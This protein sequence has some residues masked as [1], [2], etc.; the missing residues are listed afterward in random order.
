MELDISNTLKINAD[1]IVTGRTCVIGQSGSG[2]SYTVAVICEELAKNN[3]GFCIIDTEGEYFSLKE[4]Y[5]ILWIGSDPNADI[6]IAAVNMA[7]LARKI[8][9]NG[10]PA[11][12][13]VSEVDDPKVVVGEF[14]K[15][16]YKIETK[17]RQP[18]LLIIEEIDKFAPQR[19]ETLPEVEEVSRRGRKRGLG[20]MIAT[21]RPALVNKNVLSQCGNQIIGKLTIRNDLDSVKV[22]FPDKEK[23]ESLPTLKQGQFY[24]MGDIGSGQLIQVRKRLTTH[25]AVTPAIVQ[26]KAIKIEDIKAIEEEIESP[27]KESAIEEEEVEDVKKEIIPVKLEKGDAFQQIKSKAKGFI[28]FGGETHLSGFHLALRPIYLCK[29]KYLKKGLIGSNYLDMI[30]YFD[31]I[32][33]D[34]VSISNGYKIKYKTSELIGLNQADLCILKT[35]LKSSGLTTSELAYKC[36]CSE[37]S[38]RESIKNLTKKHMITYK[39]AG[40]NVLHMPFTKKQIPDINQLSEKESVAE[41]VKIS[42]RLEKEEVDLKGLREIVRGINEESDIVEHKTV[43]YPFYVA[44][45]LRKNKTE[46]IRMDAVSGKIIK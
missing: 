40:R 39:K 2:K 7:K 19:G 45:V 24:V 22:F 29:I 30:S 23:L 16:L 12:F 27:Q 36:K 42:A 25:K 46:K 43:Y 14:I 1:K 20:L 31:A 41:P 37:Q 34:C 44:N 3:I 35:T 38:V 18:Y 32:T 8:A 26:K 4:K 10:I 17:L 28:L 11:I 33:G 5:P 6:D 15:E 21:Q 13:D 9:S